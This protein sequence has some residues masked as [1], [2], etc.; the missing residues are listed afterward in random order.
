[1][2][3]P[4]TSSD[5]PA[6]EGIPDKWLDD[7]IVTALAEDLGIGSPY[8]GDHTT[9][10]TIPASAIGKAELRVKDTGVIA[11]VKFAEKVFQYLSP[12]CD[13]A[14]LIPDGATIKPGQTAFL[15]KAPVHTLLMGERLALNVMQR[16]SGIATMSRQAAI[17]VKGTRCRV[18]DTRKTTPNLRHLE[19][20]AV[21]V[22]GSH[23]HRFGLFDMIL[24][25]DN[26]VD[27]AGGVQR[28]LYATRDYLTKLGQ[29]IPVEIECRNLAEVEAAIT[30]GQG[31]VQRLLLDNMQPDELRRCVDVV[32]GQME[33]EASGGITIETLRTFAET[34]VDFISMGALTH[35]ARNL[36]LSLKAV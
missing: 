19:K 29:P 34:G 26:H 6:L 11:G 31:L 8:P 27:F 33:T 5:T 21:R 20:W 2:T 30:H 7:F 36:D 25:K 17:A 4:A 16:L 22:G 24:I 1:M 28:A 12:T 18:L 14:L 10:A 35:S 15:V 23:N 3:G 13:F 9:R 32:A